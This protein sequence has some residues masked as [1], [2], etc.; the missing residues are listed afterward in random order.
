[1]MGAAQGAFCTSTERYSLDFS[2]TA[3]EPEVHPSWDCWSVS[4]MP[5]TVGSHTPK[6]A[7][8]AHLAGMT[9][10]QDAS[11]EWVLH[12]SQSSNL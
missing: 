4:Q 9:W 1:M 11:Q 7:G 5:F 6:E 12:H 8:S 10:G 3:L 2:T